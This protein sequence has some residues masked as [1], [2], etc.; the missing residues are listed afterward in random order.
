MSLPDPEVG[1]QIP[2]HSAALPQ[3][4]QLTG[5]WTVIAPLD[6][7][8][9]SELWDVLAGEENDHLWAYL[10]EGP[11]SGPVGFQAHI[12]RKVQSQDPLH[13]AVIDKVSAKAVGM[14]ALMRVEPADRVIEVGNI[15]FSPR[16]QRTRIATEAMYLLARY[17]FEELGYRRYEWKCNSLNRA[18]R[19]AAQ[20]LGFT[21]EGIFRQHKIVKGKNRDTAWFSMLDQEW[22]Q[23]RQAFEA[24]LDPF[25]FDAGGQQKTR[26]NQ[27]L[28]RSINA[29]RA[30]VDPCSANEG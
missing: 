17:V 8:H 18:S 13:Y 9:H 19:R 22:P 27:S 2:T 30:A 7:G 15:L 26:L 12:V 4:I 24:W 1:A 28:T 3:R 21:F 5:R 20:R 16:L 10:Q 29:T 25:N 23:R 14:S 6:A 11:F